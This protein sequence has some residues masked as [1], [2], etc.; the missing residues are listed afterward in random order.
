MTRTGALALPYTGRP[1]GLWY[2]RWLAGEK[3]STGRSIRVAVAQFVVGVFLN[4]YDTLLHTKIT[5][6]IIYTAAVTYW[7]ATCTTSTV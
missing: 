6:C 4:R 2:S 5:L 1:I 3:D 7:L